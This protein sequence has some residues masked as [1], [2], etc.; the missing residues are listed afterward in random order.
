MIDINKI[1]T[2]KKEVKQALLKR[3]DKADL[4]LD[5]ILELSN[6]RKELIQRGEGLKAERNQH[7]K[8]KPTSE[9]IERMKETTKGYQKIYARIL[10][11]NTEQAKVLKSELEKVF[12][13]IQITYTENLGPIFCLHLGKKGYGVSWC[14][15]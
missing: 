7:S 14:V 2:N 6:K 9:I 11:H 10:G 15:E 1:R 12:N 8:T 5:E 4:N 3:I 13:N